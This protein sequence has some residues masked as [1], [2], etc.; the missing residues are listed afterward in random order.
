MIRDLNMQ[1]FFQKNALRRILNPSSS[2]FVASSPTFCQSLFISN[3]YHC[4]RTCSTTQGKSKDTVKPPQFF[5]NVV[6]KKVPSKSTFGNKNG[7]VLNNDMVALYKSLV[8][9]AFGFQDKLVMPD[10]LSVYFKYATA[11]LADYQLLSR[12]D[13]KQSQ[14]D[15]IRVLEADY[16]RLAEEINKIPAKVDKHGDCQPLHGIF[17]FLSQCKKNGLNSKAL[18]ELIKP[19]LTPKIVF[20]NIPSRRFSTALVFISLYEED[21]SNSQIYHDLL[22]G[23]YQ[24]FSAVIEQSTF[25][26]FNI[27]SVITYSSSIPENLKPL[28]IEEVKKKIG[29]LNNEGILKIFTFLCRGNIT[30]DQQL[31]A[32]LKSRILQMNF[33]EINQNDLAKPIANLTEVS[34]NS[35]DVEAKIVNY[36]TQNPDALTE[37]TVL[38]LLQNMDDFSPQPYLLDFLET[39]FE[40]NF[41]NTK[42]PLPIIVGCLYQIERHRKIRETLFEDF[43]KF[44]IENFQ[45]FS[46]THREIH[47]I[48][49][50]FTAHGH[51]DSVIF[52]LLEPHVMKALRKENLLRS[53]DFYKLTSDIANSNHIPSF[54]LFEIIASRITEDYRNV[55]RKDLKQFTEL[56]YPLSI[57]IAKYSLLEEK[58][59]LDKY[60][61]EIKQKVSK[62]IPIINEILNSINF[63]DIPNKTQA[64]IF[65]SLLTLDLEFPELMADCQVGQNI[66]KQ[67]ELAHENQVKKSGFAIDVYSILK[68]RN[69]EFEEEKRIYV[70]FADAFIEPDLI[71]QIEGKSHY[72]WGTFQESHQ[73]ILRD[74]HLTKLGYRI[75]KL[76]AFDFNRWSRVE[77]ESK[78]EQIYEKIF[79]K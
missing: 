58:V 21:F 12:F 25:E 41:R 49:W 60:K 76:T 46:W 63:K 17:S 45:S 73:D 47:H 70:Y 75:V 22:S 55:I 51:G 72:T 7:H 34:R 2:L 36:I 68:Q 9:G 31:M 6:S 37:L 62:L 53:A 13:K 67:I 33:K 10:G 3:T 66:I 28:L 27:L 4:S 48:F 8:C 59:Y 26:V 79:S 40:K 15:V 19:L 35:K 57:F 39:Y 69:I 77:F 30:S 50:S 11:F 24:N 20:G 18:Y 65:Q 42:I 56:I 74:Y 61:S 5:Q 14:K 44:M 38:K 23:L 54:Q 64:M 52:K 16:R 71:I 29:S 32:N 78:K 43:E 1:K